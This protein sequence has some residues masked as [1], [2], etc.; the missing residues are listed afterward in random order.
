[1]AAAV[2]LSGV[3]S[4]P[5]IEDLQQVATEASHTI[6]EIREES[7]D[8][9]QGLTTAGHDELEPLFRI[10]DAGSPVRRRPTRRARRSPG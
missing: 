3:H 10:R 7:N 2:L 1:M 8:N 9:L 5:R 4:V 6:D